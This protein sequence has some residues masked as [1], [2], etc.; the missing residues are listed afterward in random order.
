MRKNTVLFK[1]DRCGLK[2]Y[3]CADDWIAIV[4]VHYTKDYCPQCLLLLH[5]LLVQFDRQ[6]VPARD[7]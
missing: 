7:N 5:K 4:T 6:E 2:S 1:C 3:N